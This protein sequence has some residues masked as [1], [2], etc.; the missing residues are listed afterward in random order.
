[1]KEEADPQLAAEQ[2]AYLVL[3]T[4]LD[5]ALFNTQRHESDDEIET[6]VRHGV[7]KFLAGV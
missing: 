7:S 4:P 1:M 2:L 6:R 3:G 5:R